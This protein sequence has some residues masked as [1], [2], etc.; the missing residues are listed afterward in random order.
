[1]Y[2]FL[3]K[4]FLHFSW[5]APHCLPSVGGRLTGPQKGSP[6][7]TPVAGRTAGEP[8]GPADR[9]NKTAPRRGGGAGGLRSRHRRPAARTGTTFCFTFFLLAFSLSLL[10]TTTTCG[11]C[12]VLLCVCVRVSK[13]LWRRAPRWRRARRIAAQLRT[14]PRRLDVPWA[15]PTPWRQGRR[16]ARR[17]P[18]RPAAP[19]P[20]GPAARP[21]PPQPCP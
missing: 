13:T 10:W 17:V 3:Y 16:P 2:T 18:G 8:D 1:M 7:L 5:V 6:L 11:V 20:G 9:T 4:S 15:P 14:V 19:W 21:R 12:C